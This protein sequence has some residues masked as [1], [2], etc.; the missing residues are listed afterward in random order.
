MCRVCWM[1]LLDVVFCALGTTTHLAQSL[2]ITNV[3]VNDASKCLSKDCDSSLIWW[4]S[5]VLRVCPDCPSLRL[6][7]V[8]AFTE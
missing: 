5:A 2:Q 7:L 4:R 8:R 1:A 6:S 3:I